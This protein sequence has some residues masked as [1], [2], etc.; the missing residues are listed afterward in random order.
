VA[1]PAG[2]PDLFIDRSL[3][4][5]QVPALLRAAGLRLVTLAEHYGVP[6]DENVTDVTWLADVGRLGWA[7]LMKD[8]RIRYKRPERDAV[9]RHNVRCFCLTR[10]DLK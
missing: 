3:G 2:L 6:A 10:Q 1:H 4:R 7:V 5:K 8:E 9:A